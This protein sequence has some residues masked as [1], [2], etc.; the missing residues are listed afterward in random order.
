[1][2]A[3]AGDNSFW[4][5]SDPHGW[6]ELLSWPGT[7]ESFAAV[8]GGRCYILDPD[9]NG[10]WEWNPVKVGWSQLGGGVQSLDA[11]TDRA[12]NDAVFVKNLDGS[13][14]EFYH[15][16]QEL[17]D[18]FFGILVTSFSAGTDVNGNADVYVSR[19]GELERYAG[20]IWSAVAAAGSYKEFSA[21]DSGQVWIISWDNTLQKYDNSDLRHVVSTSAFL[22]ISAASSSDIYAVSSDDALWEQRPSNSTTTTTA[23]AMVSWEY[24]AYSTSSS[25]AMWYL[26]SVSGTVQQ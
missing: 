5:Y 12:G 6:T 18:P 24:S 2:F 22:S 23:S 7:V 20:G 13:F 3:I 8:K 17:A 11:V 4:E 16:Y 9:G 1:V 19:L 25:S 26:I 15:G 14:G 21:T 10:L